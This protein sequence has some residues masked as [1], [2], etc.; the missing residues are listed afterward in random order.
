MTAR[1]QKYIGVIIGA[2][3]GQIYA[4]I[5][6]DDD[7][8]LDNP[9]LLMLQAS[10]GQIMPINFDPDNPP[11]LEDLPQY[12]REPMRMVK[13]PRGQYEAANSMD[14]VAQIVTELLR[15]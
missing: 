12:E 7:S 8:E 3:T 14:V 4:V 5:N 2:N 9:R 11:R 13:V 1:S 10:A 6:P 15:K